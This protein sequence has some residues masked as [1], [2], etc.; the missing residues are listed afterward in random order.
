MRWKDKLV[1]KFNLV[2]KFNATKGLLKINL[3]LATKAYLSHFEMILSNEFS[4][5]AFCLVCISHRANDINSPG[6]ISEGHT[7]FVIVFAG[8][9]CK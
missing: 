5:T 3:Q 7:W 1:L 8:T 2:P 6:F 4:F 9:H